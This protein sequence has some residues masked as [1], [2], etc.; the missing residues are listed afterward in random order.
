M[1]PSE[2]QP[3][4][5]IQPQPSEIQPYEE[6]QPY[7]DIQPSDTELSNIQSGSQMGT[8]T[9]IS[10]ITKEADFPTT[11]IGDEVNKKLTHDSEIV[12]KE[13]LKEQPV[14]PNT[15][16]VEQ[17]NPNAQKIESESLIG[18]DTSLG[19]YSD[20]T[21]KNKTKSKNFFIKG[22]KKL[23]NLVSL[24]CSPESVFDQ[25]IKTKSKA[26]DPQATLDTTTEL[27]SNPLTSSNS[28][29]QLETLSL[30]SKELEMV[31]L[32][33]LEMISLASTFLTLVN[34]PLLNASSDIFFI[35]H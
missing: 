16:K 8:E 28:I 20:Q 35:K 18:I 13:E 4:E 2:T 15:Q 24:F 11:L 10:D 9:W 3:Y 7:D 21:K 27:P 26:K 19:L 17:V 12:L 25:A 31:S 29:K 22:L 5:E 30:A 6:I 33:N 1:Q 32:P 34:R 14:N 23:K